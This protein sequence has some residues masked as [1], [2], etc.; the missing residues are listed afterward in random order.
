MANYDTNLAAEY[1]VMSCLHRL[2][3][4]ASLTLGNKKG[5]DILVARDNGDTVTV[6][7]K[8]VA[9]RYD[10]TLGTINRDELKR[11]NRHYFVLVTFNGNIA[12]PQMPSPEVWVVPSPS[13]DPFIRDYENRTNVSRA[14]IVKAGADYKHAW[15][16]ISNG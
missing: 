5:V 1:H 2:G 6:E 3:I 11:R 15:S 9:K 14:E 16:F 4:T 12:D 10:W 13:L 7:V 8:G